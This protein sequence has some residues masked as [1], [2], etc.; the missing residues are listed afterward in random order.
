MYSNEDH[1]KRVRDR[2][3]HEGLDHFTD[4]HALELLLFYAIPRKDTK[5]L[6][7]A[8]LSRFG[9]FSQVLEA[10]EEELLKVD[11]V[12]INTATYI[13]LLNDLCR[14]NQ[15]SSLKTGVIL[16]DSTEYGNYVLPFFTGR[17]NEAVVLLCMDAKCKVRSCQVLSEGDVNAIRLPIREVVEAA[18]AANATTVVLAHNHPSGIAL[19]SR[20]DLAVTEQIAFALGNLGI[21]MADHIIVA[22]GD[23]TSIAASGQ[24]DPA[25]YCRLG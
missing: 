20:E 13:R 11:G 17:R 9:S 10:T 25:K 23:F 7:R 6:A 3:R 14:Y 18:L 21:Y 4:V 12:G 16:K 15:M 8:L 22:N 5:D 1:R 19:P 24:H 2:F